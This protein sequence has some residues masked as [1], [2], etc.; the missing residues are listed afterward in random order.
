MFKESSAIE[1]RG[2]CMRC[3]SPIWDRY[4]VRLNDFRDEE[5]DPSGPDTVWIP[6]GT[7]DYP[8][9]VTPEFHF[10]VESQLPW[11]QFDDDLP[12]TRSEDDPGIAAAFAAAK[13][14]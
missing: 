4:L 3:G 10:G 9:R 11:V 7:L 14:G 2:F 12:R 5:G 6:I 8:E 13:R 1:E